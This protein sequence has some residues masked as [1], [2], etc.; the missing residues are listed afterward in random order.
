MESFKP[1]F[2]T[3]L[4]NWKRENRI[5]SIKRLRRLFKNQQFG[6][7][8]FSRPAFNRCLALIVKIRYAHLEISSPKA[9][10]V[11]SPLLFCYSFLYSFFLSFFFFFCSTLPPPL[12]NGLTVENAFVF[13]KFWFNFL[14]PWYVFKRDFRP[15][16]LAIFRYV[17]TEKINYG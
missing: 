9:S 6:P 1:T 7:G 2:L 11:N 17:L 3:F 5:L 10:S 14:M 15:T 4:S 13:F 12:T 16:V 8:V